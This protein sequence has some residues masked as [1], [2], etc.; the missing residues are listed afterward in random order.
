[1]LLCDCCNKANHFGCLRDV[2]FVQRPGENDDFLCHDCIQKAINETITN[3]LP[4]A[5]KACGLTLST[6]PKSMQSLKRKSRDDSHSTCPKLEYSLRDTRFG[7]GTELYNLIEVR[8]S[9]KKNTCFV[10][11][12]LVRSVELTTISPISHSECQ[13]SWHL[14]FDI[15]VRRWYI[16]YCS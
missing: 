3:P 10:W 4:A 2:F 8:R 5:T 6:S 16:L 9:T 12:F 7:F 1:L 13:G 14:S 11:L 15:L